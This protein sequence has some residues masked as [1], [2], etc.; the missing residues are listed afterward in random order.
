MRIGEN[1]FNYSNRWNVSFSTGDK[2]IIRKR[3]SI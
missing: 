1:G 2:R 3:K